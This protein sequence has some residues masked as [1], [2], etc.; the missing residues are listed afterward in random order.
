MASTLSRTCL[1]S[2]ADCEAVGSL[3]PLPKPLTW[4]TR[5][6][7]REAVKSS[8]STAVSNTSNDTCD[9]ALSS[10]PSALAR[11]NNAWHCFL[12]ADS[13]SASELS[14][15]S[16]MT[17]PRQPSFDA[18]TSMF[19]A[20]RDSVEACTVSGAFS[21]AS[22]RSF[23]SSSSGLARSGSAPSASSAASLGFSTP[24]SPTLA[25]AD[26]AFAA[27]SLGFSASG[28]SDA[29]T[30]LKVKAT[31]RVFIKAI[32]SC[33]SKSSTMA[34]LQRTK[35]SPTRT[36]FSHA[37]EFSSTLLTST[38]PGGQP[39]GV[40]PSFVPGSVASHSKVVLVGS[41]IEAAVSSTAHAELTPQASGA[42]TQHT[43]CAGA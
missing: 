29:C 2:S 41:S 13:T 26:S 40:I 14:D 24:G 19:Q 39:E 30:R 1:S 8:R 35:V 16:F 17:L 37:Q 32:K 21:E 18:A 7:V 34:P 42:G 28:A 12:L 9:R 10:R 31:G 20:C 36:P 33:F 3:K 5:L 43:C 25:S 4:S 23:A 27:G 15:I 11:E 22:G 6:P 38:G